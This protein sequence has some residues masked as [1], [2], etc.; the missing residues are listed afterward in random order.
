[1][2]PANTI[3]LC[4][5]MTT[6]RGAARVCIIA[7]SIFMT[8]QR[9]AR[10]LLCLARQITPRSEMLLARRPPH[11]SLVMEQNDRDFH[12]GFS[13]TIKLIFLHQREPFIGAGIVFLK[14][15]AAD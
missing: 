4:A 9:N 3:M 5:V 13:F 11:S 7:F 6:R 8:A 2:R 1:M 12:F 15:R 14:M 10:A